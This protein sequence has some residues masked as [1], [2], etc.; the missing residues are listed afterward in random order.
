MKKIIS[1]IA[2][3]LLLVSCIDTVIL[4]DDKTV[5]EDFWQTKNDVTLMVNGAYS[6]MATSGLQQ[7]LVV[8]TSRSDELNLNS[9]LNNRD[10]NQIYSANIQTTNGYANWSDLYAVI[11]ACNLVIAK[12]E[13]VMDIDPNYMEGDHLNNVAQMKALRSLCYFYL[14]RVFR[15][16][17]LILEPY[18]NSSQEM[19]VPQVAPS[20]VIDQ[21]IADLEEVKN[22]ALST[23]AI[24][25]ADWTRCGYFTRDGI[26]A[27]L[28]DVYLWKASIYG[29]EYCYDKVIEYSNIIRRNRENAPSNPNSFGAQTLDD[30]GWG[31]SPASSYYNQ[32]FSENGNGQESLFELQFTNNEGLC[33]VYNR[34]NKNANAQPQFYASKPYAKVG[35]GRANYVF[36]NTSHYVNDVRGFESV[37]DFNGAAEEGFFIRKHVGMN[38]LTFMGQN[39]ASEIRG[40]RAFNPYN[41]NWV[42]YRATD[43]M[44]MKAEALV[45]KAL[46]QAKAQAGL[47]EQLATVSTV[48]D[49]LALADQLFQINQTISRYNVEAVRQVQIVN[50]RAIHSTDESTKSP[51]D[52]TK[53]AVSSVPFDSIDVAG[54]VNRQVSAFNSF[55]ATASDLELLVMDERARE[56]CFEG[57]RWFDMLRYNYRHVDGVNYGVILAHQGDYVK[58]YDE[59]LNLIARKYTSGGGKGVTAKMPTE[60]YLYM[61]IIESEMEVNN[62][63]EQNPVY[64][65][66]GTIEKN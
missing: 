39:P 20:V 27:L 11:N 38:G 48:E 26:Y 30:D 43:V 4:P 47:V 18:K 10:L 52:S 29:D 65:D 59:M 60:P 57:K 62:A 28:A 14:V 24:P 37:Y 17:P 1:I 31:L 46:I 19:N 56:L 12:S 58:N 45:Q 23:Q 53:Y 2:S 5:E 13:E 50:T 34:V 36:D 41:Q 44:L 63:L 51:I 25:V 7:R 22:N 66:G 55:A 33:I 32:L 3:G 42:V 35:T 40:N 61:P 9:S 49:S 54:Y 8:W 15:D 64:S 16:V 6:K 21:I